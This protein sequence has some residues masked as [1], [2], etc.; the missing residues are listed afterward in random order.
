MGTSSLSKDDDMGTKEERNEL[1]QIKVCLYFPKPIQWVQKRCAM[2]IGK[3]WQVKQDL[4]ILK[5]VYQELNHYL[6]QHILP[7]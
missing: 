7:I 1:H 3:F 2:H 4:E 6:V 5:E